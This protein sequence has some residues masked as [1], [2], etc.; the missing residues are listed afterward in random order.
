[1]G[2]YDIDGNKVCDY[3]GI[4]DLEGLLPG[5]LLI[6]HDEFNKPLDKTKWV[7]TYGRGTANTNL[8]YAKDI[9][10]VANSGNGLQYRTI[11]DNPTTN[12]DYR[13]AYICTKNCFEF[14]YGRIEAKI[15]FP[16]I[17]PH[18][19]TFW[20]L[21]ANYDCIPTG[22]YTPWNSEA[23]VKFPSCGE[24]D[25][26]EYDNGSVGAR[27]HWSSSGLDTS[28]TYKTGGNVA[29][30]TNTPT[31]WH[32]YACEWTATTIAFYV[33]GVQKGTWSTSN[34]VVNGYN[35]FNH[36]HYIIFNCIIALSGTPSWEIANTDV[37]WV[38]VYAPEGVTEYITE[39]GI[40]VDASA[41]ISVGERKWLEP[42]FAPS[43]PSDM[44]L[45]WVSHNDDIVTCHGGLLIGISAGTTYVQCTTK[46]GLT[47]M[48]KVTVS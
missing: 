11:K 37:A 22:E 34:A 3:E 33:D 20:T 44:T 45:N 2:L 6:W 47:A 35:P 18:H 1:M 46:H 31:Q 19:S 25:I 15:K 8:S 27:T 17:S 30:L 32:I 28:S 13:S 9:S 36:P 16:N 38:R 26:A 21:G 4:A 5:R 12:F 43:V 24:I 14:M 40:S 23:G 29:S 39:T 10:L 41:S 42:V 48:C 7:N